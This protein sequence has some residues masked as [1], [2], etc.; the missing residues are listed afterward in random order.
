MSW[1]PDPWTGAPNPMS[2]RM[3]ET[4][5]TKIAAAD[6]RE[7]A[8][9]EREYSVSVLVDVEAPEPSLEI[10]P[11]VSFLSAGKPVGVTFDAKA[12]TAEQHAVEATRRSLE[13]MSLKPRFL[14][15]ARV[16]IV[17][18]TPAQLRK[19]LELPTVRSAAPNREAKLQR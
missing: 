8:A 15:A 18:T 2:E 4:L 1:A 14:K 17:R 5:D 10:G 12:S 6:L 19:I 16:F 11:G 9:S 13:A 7:F 3:A